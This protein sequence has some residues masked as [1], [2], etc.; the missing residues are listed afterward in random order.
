MK[1]ITSKVNKTSRPSNFQVTVLSETVTL[2]PPPIILRRLR[3]LLERK[4][5]RKEGKRNEGRKVGRRKSSQT[6]IHYLGFPK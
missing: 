4:N 1:P 6:C 5:E 2:P 3:I